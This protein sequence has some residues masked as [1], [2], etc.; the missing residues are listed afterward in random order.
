MKL[1]RREPTYIEKELA[2]IAWFAS[3]LSCMEKDRSPLRRLYQ[4]IPIYPSGAA[5]TILGQLQGP[6]LE[7]VRAHTRKKLVALGCQF[8]HEDDHARLR[9]EI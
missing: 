6:S 3:N 2:K 8:A 1:P 4:G 9:N 5:R 7:N